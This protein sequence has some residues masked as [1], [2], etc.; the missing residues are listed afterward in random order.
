[1]TIF[2]KGSEFGGMIESVI[3]PD[4]QSDSLKNE[5]AAIFADVPKDRMILHLGKELSADFN[6]LI[7]IRL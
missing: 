2:D 6:L 7:L 4:K 5:I 3:P 1:V